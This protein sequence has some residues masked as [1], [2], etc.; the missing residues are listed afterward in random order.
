M[1]GYFWD[2]PESRTGHRFDE[3]FLTLAWAQG[4]AC[5]PRTIGNNRL[6]YLSIDQWICHRWETSRTAGGA[7]RISYFAG[8]DRTVVVE[9]LRQDFNAHRQ[10]EN[11]R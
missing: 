6:G 2:D 5:L 11:R 3:R 8:T 9:S 4:G 1:N 7:F 10:S